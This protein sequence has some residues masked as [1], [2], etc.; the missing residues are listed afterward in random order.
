MQ[1]PSAAQFAVVSSFFSSEFLGAHE[2]RVLA[3]PWGDAEV[4]L[5]EVDGRVVACI[6]RYGRD[7]ALPSHRI[8]FRANL[9]ALRL[10]GV[11]RVVSQNAIG[12]CNPDLPP[13]S[14][15]VSDDFIDFTHGRPRSFFDDAQAWVRVD[16]TQPF[17]AEMRSHL[18]AAAQPIFPRLAERG[19]F[20]CV[21]GPRF[22]T[23][24][25]IRMFR[26]WGADIIGTPLVPEVVLAREAE[27]CFASIA[28]IINFAAGMA[29]AVVHAGPGSMV[30]FYYGSGFH[31]RVESAIRQA[32]GTLAGQERAC[33]CG[34]ALEGAFHG[35]PPAWFTA[36][37]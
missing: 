15:V 25:E 26:Q 27:L 23:P 2:T 24:A 36:R 17:C 29:P 30:D 19:T 5:A 13:G 28:P 12:S 35:T 8:N 1:S 3:T 7:L 18:I 14:V 31:A 33:G 22:E 9:W 10:L 16:L 6:W 4:D 21:E 37:Y 34:R 32:L 11:E 20:I